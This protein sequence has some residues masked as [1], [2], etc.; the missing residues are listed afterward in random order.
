M[1][2]DGSAKVNSLNKLFLNEKDRRAR[3]LISLLLICNSLC[4]GDGT[5][6]LTSG[7][8][9]VNIPNLGM[10]TPRPIR[11]LRLTY[12]PSEFQM[13]RIYSSLKEP[14]TRYILR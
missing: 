4:E 12:S 13:T 2:E 8:V 7:G 9:K 14:S 3:L 6:N 11:K 5:F 10:L 1:K